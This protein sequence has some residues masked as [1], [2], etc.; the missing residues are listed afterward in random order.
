VPWFD[1]PV[2]PFEKVRI[3][4]TRPDPPETMNLRPLSALLVLA[5]TTAAAFAQAPDAPNLSRL[6]GDWNGAHGG[7]WRVV[8]DEQTG[9]LQMLWGGRAESRSRAVVDED[10]FQLAREALAATYAFHGI[11]AATLEPQSTLHLPLGMIGSSDKMTVRFRQQVGGVAVE[12]GFVNVLFDMQG[13]LLSVHSTGMPHVAGFDVAAR[14]D[15]DRATRSAI[16]AFRV[17]SGVLE[18][19][20]GAAELV[21]D[22]DFDGEQRLPRLAWKI[23]VRSETDGSEPVGFEWFVDAKTGAAYRS[24][25]SVHFFDVSGSV[26]ASSTPGLSSDHP[27]NPAVQQPMQQL[28]VTSGA[29]TTMTDASG[30]FTLVGVNAP[31]SVTV[32]FSGTYSNVNNAAGAD[33]S[34]T[35]NLTLPTGNVIQMAPTPTEHTTAQA[36]AM[37]SALLVRDF[38][39]ATN[40]SDTHADFVVVQSVNQASSCNASWSGNQTNY[41]VAGSGCS[42]FAFS[43]IVAHELGHWLNSIYGTGNGSDGMGEGNADVWAMYT[44]DSPIIGQGA[45]NGSGFVRTGN[46]NRQFCGDANPGC[47]GGVHANGEVWMAA[48][49]KI[50]NRLNVTFGNTIGDQIANT[51]FLSWMNGYNQTQIRTVIETQWLTLDDDDGN[52]NN[53]TPHYAQIDG[54]FRDQ[55]FPG[56]T[57]F[58]VGIDQVTLLSDTT[59]QTVDYNVS[60]RIVA[61]QSPPITTAQLKYRLNGG[62]FQTVN[63][64]AGP[65]D[66]YMASIP[67]QLGRTKVEYYVTATN[68]A[69]ST[70]V[71]PQGSPNVPFLFDVGIKHE[72]AAYTFDGGVN[73]QGWTHGG[74]SDEWQRGDPAGK[75]GT[76]WAD[77]GA[78]YSPTA[79]WGTDLG[80]STGGSYSSNSNSWLRTPVFNCTGATG[81]RL[82]FNR[83]LSV[84]ASTSDQ[85]RIRV[86]GSQVYINPTSNMNDGAWVAQDIDISALADNNPSVQIEWAMQANGSTNYG[87]WNIDDVKLVWVEGLPVPCAEAQNFCVGAPNSTGI[88][89]QVLV[90]GTPNISLNDLSV[91]A[92]NLPPGTAGIFFYGPNAGQIPFGNG[93]ICVTGSTYRLPVVFADSLGLASYMIDY[94]NLPHPIVAND[95]WRFQFWYRDIVL[96]VPGF[97]L[98]DGIAVTFCP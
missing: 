94:G 48:A 68:N 61:N 11:D 80:T 9:F 27:G 14:I 18:T 21:V 3:P 70:S 95:V 65:N 63:M 35:T 86:N 87:G 7:N 93:F 97:N 54:G 4:S 19:S 15:T 92:F 24:R 96:G 37:R 33:Y 55:G 6:L 78:A 41:Y 51:I 44:Y 56:V 1:H 32:E 91:W 59:N 58:Q 39:K 83:W 73:D 50:R 38:I 40:P 28:K 23:D 64:F 20:F 57:L 88:G 77:P 13:R 72:I 22:Q 69:A 53:G 2:A 29:V 71:F 31:A 10:Y 98:S 36:N 34:L 74:T 84:Q 30:N 76:G 46:N 12:G 16:A 17:K 85:A 45:N 60:A 5:S 89:A 62:A 25:E 8:P 66:I 26:T 67:A 82:R 79:S 49:W 81:M 75:T 52:I 47:H 90:N 42:N 43:T